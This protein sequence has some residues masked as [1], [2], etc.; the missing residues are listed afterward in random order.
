MAPEY[1]AANLPA[2]DTTGT[3][4]DETQPTTLYYFGKNGNAFYAVA[5]GSGV[6]ELV[7]TDAIMG[8]TSLKA[9]RNTENAKGCTIWTR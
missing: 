5:S 1:C 8:G 7:D 2:L 3:G 9:A 6:W 4:S